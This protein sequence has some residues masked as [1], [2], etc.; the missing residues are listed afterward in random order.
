M[1]PIGRMIVSMTG[2]QATPSVFIVAIREM[3]RGAGQSKATTARNV[4]RA[5][6]AVWSEHKYREARRRLIHP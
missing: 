3:H 6:R 2:D 5:V 1:S 4:W